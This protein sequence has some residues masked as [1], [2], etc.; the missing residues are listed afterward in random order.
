VEEPAPVMDAGLKLAVA[1][2][3]NPV[4]LKLTVLAKPLTSAQMEAV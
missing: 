1:F 3:G 2:A 4:T